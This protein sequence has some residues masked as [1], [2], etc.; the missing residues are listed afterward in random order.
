M[1]KKIL[2]IITKSNWGG[3]QRYVFDLATHLPK[4]QF[5]PVVAF[6]GTGEAGATAGIL[7][8]KLNA[9]GIRTIFISSLT[10]DVSWTKEFLV[11][12]DLTRLMRAERPD[13]V[14]LNSSK[15]AAWGAFV[16]FMIGV[17][18]VVFTVHGW[19]FKEYRNFLATFLIKEISWFTALLSDATIVVS[20][21]DEKIGKRLLGLKAKIQYVPLGIEMPEFLSCDAASEI[22][23]P[24]ADAWP[25]IV[26]IA[27]LTPNKGISFAIDAIALLKERAINI[28]YYIV[29]EGEERVRLFK[30]AEKSG[31]SDRV[32]F[33]GF[34]PDAA[35]YLKAFDIFLLPSLKEGMPYVL[36]ESIAAGLPIV[37][38]RVVDVIFLGTMQGI[39]PVDP[40]D[41]TQ[42]ADAIEKLLKDGTT[43]VPAHEQFPFPLSRTLK[44]TIDL[45]TTAPTIS[46]SSRA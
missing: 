38:T 29:G 27:E 41:A 20:K 3:A 28:D 22:I 37:T 32:H 40:A 2:Y 13:I 1:K 33:L 17:P 18:R 21:G 9:A 46:V 39:S 26:T 11:W 19:P 45:Y 15:V 24:T 10:R 35:R 25:R 8:E 31:V 12:R 34:V 16:A 30:V 7:Q 42:I 44:E 6:G 5:E 14:H 36:F 4:D 43:S 23:S